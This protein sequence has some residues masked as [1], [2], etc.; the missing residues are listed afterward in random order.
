MSML[1]T[2]IS[3][4]KI[5]IDPAAKSIFPLKHKAYTYEMDHIEHC[6]I[7]ETKSSGEH[8]DLITVMYN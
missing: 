2:G 7:I 3:S 5:E 8:H 6:S 4:G 1:L